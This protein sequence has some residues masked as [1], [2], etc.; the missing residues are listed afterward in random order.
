MSPSQG[1]RLRVAIVGGGI[2]GVDHAQAYRAQPDA[3]LVAVV[4]RDWARTAAVAERFG[5]RPYLD[6]ASMLAAE[7]VDAVSICTPTGLHRPFVEVAAAAGVHVLVEKPMATS[8]VECDQIARACRTAGVVLML[9]LTH[10]FHA[11]LIEAR[12]LIEEGRLG[13]PMLAQDMFS[14]GEHGPWPDWY[15]DRGLAGGGELMHDA[16]HMVDRL[17]WL[18][19]SPIVEVYGLTTTYARGL[20]GVE[21]GGVAVLSFESGA[22]GSLFVNEATHPIR[23]D[24]ASVPMPGRMELEIHG[25]RGTIRYRT[26]HELVVDIAGEPSRTIAREGPGDEMRREIREFL[27]AIGE[28]RSPSVGVAEGRRG[29]AVVQAIYESARRGRP[30]RV[31][32][33]FPAPAEP[34]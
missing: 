27:D 19:G 8:V 32:E 31:D 11:E 22:I 24:A 28:R 15:Y 30:V 6:M 33:L 13:P 26:W 7:A 16:V 20:P 25:P 34:R 21:D 2:V 17:G 1:R 9:G 29:I 12:R 4:G 14:F 10:R 18:V 23:S 3:E 5:A